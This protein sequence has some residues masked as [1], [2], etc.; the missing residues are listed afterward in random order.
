VSVEAG[1]RT[2]LAVTILGLLLLGM[3]GRIA[4]GIAFSPLD[5]LEH[6]SF[7]H[8]AELGRI[9]DSSTFTDRDAHPKYQPADGVLVV[10]I[11]GSVVFARIRSRRVSS[12]AST[13]RPG[14]T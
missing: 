3:L 6:A 13:T 9:P 10:G 1:A 12:R 2:Q 14:S 11:D 5:L 4:L 7:P 8:I